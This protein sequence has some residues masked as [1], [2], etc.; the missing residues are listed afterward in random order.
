ML[1]M[2][3][4]T[5]EQAVVQSKQQYKNDNSGSLATTYE[6][7]QTNHLTY[8]HYKER[9][10]E[11]PTRRQGRPERNN[12]DQIVDYISYIKGLKPAPTKIVNAAQDRSNWR[13]IFVAPNKPARWWWLPISLGRLLRYC[14]NLNILL[15]FGFSKSISCFKV[16]MWPKNSGS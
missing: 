9:A 2:R 8:T 3:N 15:V 7:Q 13:K 5:N 4:Y 6:W 10:A 12:Y 14:N 16:E 11:I 1:Q